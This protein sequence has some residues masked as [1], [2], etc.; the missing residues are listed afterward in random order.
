MDGWARGIWWGRGSGGGVD[1]R[2]GR[3]GDHTP[4]PR[5]NRHSIPPP[6]I[7]I[8]ATACPKYL[9]SNDDAA[10]G[11]SRNTG[12]DAADIGLRQDELVERNIARGAEGDFLNGAGHLGLSATGAE[13]R[14][15]RETSTLKPDRTPA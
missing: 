6:G 2:R 11:L 12:L 7:T 5:P 14:S 4:I 3:S 15:P 8:P 13:I 1:V 9:P 10:S